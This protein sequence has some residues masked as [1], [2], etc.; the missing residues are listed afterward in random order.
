M[1]L[2]EL[3][4]A[5][6]GAIRVEGTRDGTRHVDAL[7]DADSTLAG[8]PDSRVES[9][10]GERKGDRKR[11]W[12]GLDI[13]FPHTEGHSAPVRHTY[14]PPSS[15]LGLVCLWFFQWVLLSSGE[16][17]LQAAWKILRDPNET[18][19]RLTRPQDRFQVE[20]PHLRCTSAGECSPD[21]GDRAQ[22]PNLRLLLVDL[23]NSPRNHLT[24]DSLKEEVARSI[25]S[26]FQEF[27]LRTGIQEFDP[28]DF[29]DPV[30]ARTGNQLE[31]E[32]Q[33]KNIIGVLPGINWGTREDEITVVGA[34]YDTVPFTRGLDDNGSGVAALIETARVS[35]GV[36]VLGFR[37]GLESRKS[38]GTRSQA[39][40]EYNLVLLTLVETE[41]KR[42]K[43]E[44]ERDERALR[45]STRLCPTGKRNGSEDDET[46]L[47]IRHRT[48]N[49]KKG[50]LTQSYQNDIAEI[51]HKGRRTRRRVTPVFA[52]HS[53][54]G[55]RTNS[56]TYLIR[57]EWISGH[58]QKMGTAPARRGFCEFSR[59][60]KTGR[61][62]EN[63]EKALDSLLRQGITQDFGKKLEEWQRMKARTGNG[64]ESGKGNG[65]DDLDPSVSRTGRS[66][67]ESCATP[68]RMNEISGRVLREIV[69][70]DRLRRSGETTGIDDDFLSGVPLPVGFHRWATERGILAFRPWIERTEGSLLQHSVQRGSRWS[71]V[72]LS[73]KEERKRGRKKKDMQWLEKELHKIEKEKQ[74]LEKER[75]KYRER[76]ERLEKIR[77]AMQGHGPEGNREVLV[78]TSTGEYQAG[79][80]AGKIA[81]FYPGELGLHTVQRDAG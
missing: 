28:E 45:L 13:P 32:T 12:A 75:E 59:K 65:V 52:I 60:R 70:A 61:A 74:R 80:E 48:P 76:E 31:L 33:G 18:V 8:R 9:A 64:K 42:K 72:T 20:R 25:L 30:A 35:L 34:H 49:V 79:Q 62:E 63:V 40:A 1:P 50:I 67:S 46:P 23:F 14:L 4:N 39:F 6:V 3:V 5:P 47:E 36:T 24:N 69:P 56:G 15:F 19:F 78:R 54:Q 77:E 53:C 55:D 7:P 73:P 37:V 68:I 81:G 43:L 11:K 71:G 22:L 2:L 44:T 29:P 21:E 27:E 57:S 51:G 66:K 10:F 38:K 26:L 17:I 16:N 41:E 58:S